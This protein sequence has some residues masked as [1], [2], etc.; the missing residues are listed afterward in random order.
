MRAKVNTVA[1][2]NWYK[3]LW[4]LVFRSLPPSPT[5]RVDLLEKLLFRLLHHH[6][7]DD[8]KI[9][10]ACMHVWALARRYNR[11]LYQTASFAEVLLSG[12]EDG[13]AMLVSGPLALELCPP[14][15]RQPA[16]LGQ[17]DLFELNAE[18]VLQLFGVW[19]RA[20]LDRL[21][22]EFETR[23]L[24]KEKTDRVTFD[25]K[26]L[27]QLT[28]FS[29]LDHMMGCG[30]VPAHRLFMAPSTQN[31]YA[32]IRHSGLSYEDQVVAAGTLFDHNPQDYVG[33]A[34]GMCIVLAKMYGLPVVF[35]DEVLWSVGL[36]FWIQHDADRKHAAIV[37]NQTVLALSSLLDS[38]ALLFLA[39]WCFDNLQIGAAAEKS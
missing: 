13:M 18:G 17:T 35:V 38:D 10:V 30:V 32:L 8:E 29:R 36:V 23:H 21:V 28:D 9:V 5:L 12:D 25:V 6:S 22:V 14:H 16:A 34:L 39:Q 7:R 15:V 4:H 19:H 27:P 37:K 3:L 11:A 2:V 26:N 24:L 1:L 31:I 33:S 20:E